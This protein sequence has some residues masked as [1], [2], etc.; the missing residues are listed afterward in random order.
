MDLEEIEEPNVPVVIERKIHGGKGKP[1]T[2]S[3]KANLAL[4]RAKRA[5]MK[6]A[7]AAEEAE[8]EEAVKK[9]LVTKKAP[10]PP[11]PSPPPP[12]E[13]VKQQLVKPRQRKAEPE[14]EPEPVKKKKK[15]QVIIV[16]ADSSS[17]EEPQV[18]YKT[19]PKKRVTTPREP[20][21]EEPLEIPK[22]KRA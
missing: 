12:P 14:P 16:E 10:P 1:M 15:K 21:Y 4:G 9:A 22:M 5:G 18:I 19:K 7:K 6:A 8:E 2:E 11:P 20:V 13:P 3:Q 17:D